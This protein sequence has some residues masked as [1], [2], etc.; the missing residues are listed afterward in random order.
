MKSLPFFFLLIMA[1][2]AMPALALN[3]WTVTDKGSI[4]LYAPNDLQGG[5]VFAYMVSGPYELD[6]T[7]LK[8]WFS[9]WARKMQE[10]F[11]KPLNEWLV[12]PDKE[13][14]SITNQYMDKKSGKRLSVG[15]EGG[16]LDSKRAY[17]VT[18]LSSVDLMLILK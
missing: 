16:M 10:R 5:K 11:G 1:L 12:K 3:G 9:G 6:G 7:E 13:T 17:F 15:Y 8:E 2:T 14:W 18:M 4:R